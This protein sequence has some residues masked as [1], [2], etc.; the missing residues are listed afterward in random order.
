MAADAW[1][2]AGSV[3]VLDQEAEARASRFETGD[4]YARL[5]SEGYRFDFFEAVRLLEGLYPDAPPIGET[6]Y[7]REE[8]I[9][10]HPNTS[11]LFPASDVRK[12][13]F[14][15]AERQRAEVMVTFMG[16]YGV[17]SPLP[18]FIRE[19][20]ALEQDDSAPLRDFLDMFN[21]RLYSLFYRAWKKYRPEVGGRDATLGRESDRF[22]ALAGLGTPR[23]LERTTAPVEKLAHLAGRLAGRARNGE[24]LRTLITLILRLPAAVLENV[25]QWVPIGTRPCMGQGG[26]VLGASATIGERV[27]DESGK[28]RIQ[29]GPMGLSDFVSLLPG[30][31]AA[32]LLQWLVRLY[33]PDYL[34]YDVELRLKADEAQATHLGNSACRLGL[35]TF[36]GRPQADVVSRTVA[37]A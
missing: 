26:F 19:R 33:A 24:G 16:L 22:L 21:H 18:D 15:D 32:R 28:F 2:D 8:R 35:T 1:S 5:G 34:N 37:Y 6:P 29:L 11:L 20:I 9:R 30:G 14:S 13:T 3:T 31:K 23:A 25:P 27:Y 7:F 17:S 12:V 10:I 4:I 36:L